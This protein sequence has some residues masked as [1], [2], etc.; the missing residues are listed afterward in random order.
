MVHGKAVEPHPSQTVR[1]LGALPRRI[2]LQP[3]L[4][5]QL[6]DAL[7]VLMGEEHLDAGAEPGGIPAAQR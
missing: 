7:G 5:Q 2:E 4:L 6:L 1:E 3:P